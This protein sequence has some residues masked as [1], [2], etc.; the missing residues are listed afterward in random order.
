MT[1]SKSY[2]SFK[3]TLETKIMKTPKGVDSIPTVGWQSEGCAVISFLTQHMI[4]Q[5]VTL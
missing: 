3:F 1:S 2:F 5:T 4:S